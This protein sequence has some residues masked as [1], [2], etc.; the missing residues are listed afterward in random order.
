MDIEN[1]EFVLNTIH[2]IQKQL[3]LIKQL[4]EDVTF[5]TKK[6]EKQTTCKKKKRK[7]REL[8]KHVCQKLASFMNLSIPLVSRENVLRYVSNYVITNNL[9]IPSDKRT[10][11]ID[12]KLSEL[13]KL[14]EGTIINFLSINKYISYLIHPD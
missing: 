3:E 14:K 11:R 8:E 5:K 12:S 6:I 4:C 13:L 2:D 7:K 1:D 10:F 9:Q